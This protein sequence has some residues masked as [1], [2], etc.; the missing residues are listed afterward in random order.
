MNNLYYGLGYKWDGKPSAN[1]NAYPISRDDKC[2]QV[3]KSIER[4]PDGYKSSLSSQIQIITDRNLT[5][6]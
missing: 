5:E 6:K 2:F 3:K 4:K 1:A